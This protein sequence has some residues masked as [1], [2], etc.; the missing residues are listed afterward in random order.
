VRVEEAVL[1]GDPVFVRFAAGAGGTGLGAFRKS[2]DTGSAAQVPNGA[3]YMTTASAGSL[4]LVEVN[5]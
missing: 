1:P 2:A 5:L 4:A 3:V